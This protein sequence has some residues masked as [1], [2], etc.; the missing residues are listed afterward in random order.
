MGGNTGEGYG[1]PPGD[2]RAFS[3]RTGKLVWQFH[4]IPHPGEPG[5]ETWE[6]KDAWKTAGGVNN[7][8]G[9][10]VD[11]KRGIAYLGLGSA[12]YDFYGG[13]RLGANLYANSLVA[14]DVKTGK[15]LWYYQ[16]VHH[17][18]W[19][20]DIT[21]SPVLMQVRRNGKTIDAVVQATKTGFLFVFDRVTGKPVFPIEERAVPK[22]DIEGEGAWPTQ[23]FS[24]L[25]P[26]ARQKFTEADVDPN[27][28][29]D[30]RKAV[31]RADPRCAE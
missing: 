12:T 11:E 5:Y 21:S 26:F 3:V 9:M 19:D 16:T 17:D 20:Y 15:L 24:T 23:P 1:A 31:I 10:S 28:P 27:L 4:V 14:L 22:S 2:I 6:N 25:P 30:E 7:W 13:D 18:L 8:G 29:E